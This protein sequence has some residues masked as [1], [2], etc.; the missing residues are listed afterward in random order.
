MDIDVGQPFRRISYDRAARELGGSPAFWKMHDLLFAHQATL[1]KGPWADLA[2]QAGLDGA[3]VADRVARR[4][5]L[6]RV[7]EDAAQGGAV[8][9][10]HTPFLLLDGRPV[11]DW[12]R[13]EVW[14]ALVGGTE[15]RRFGQ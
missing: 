6:Q 4:V 15:V 5:A 7:I 1:E 13:I 8:R 3:A 9:V 2:R 12:S 11:D 14:Q 10:D